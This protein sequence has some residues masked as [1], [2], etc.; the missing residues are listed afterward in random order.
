MNRPWMTYL[1]EGAIPFLIG[2][3]LYCL[4]IYGFTRWEFPSEKLRIINNP[5][6]VSLEQIRA[7]KSASLPKLFPP[8]KVLGWA[9][10]LSCYVS[11]ITWLLWQLLRG[12]IGPGEKP[13][14]GWW[15]VLSMTLCALVSCFFTLSLLK[16]LAELT[17]DTSDY[18]VFST[19]FI[20]H[21][22]LFAG[23]VGFMVCILGFTF[24]E[25]WEIWID[26]KTKRYNK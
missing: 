9:F 8:K 1:S 15:L 17:F 16:Y 5:T 7:V 4:L 11:I 2:L 14:G 26:H 23:I 3:I 21:S 13:Y 25:M 18:P 22:I 6:S 19:N 20:V 24:M 10:M 12:R